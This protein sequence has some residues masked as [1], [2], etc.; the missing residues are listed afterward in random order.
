MKLYHHIKR[1]YKKNL[2]FII[3]VLLLLLCFYVRYPC[4]QK[5]KYDLSEEELISVLREMN[6]QELEKEQYQPYEKQ[7]EQILKQFMQDIKF[8][9]IPLSK[10]N[11]ERFVH[12]ENSWGMGRTFGGN[13][14]HEGTDLMAD[15]QVSG[16][17]PVISVS[18]GVVEKKGWLT[19]GGNRL[20][21]RCKN[22]GKFYY[23]HLAD[24]AEGIEE[25]KSV[26]AGQLLGFM[27]DTGYGPEGTKGKF[28]VHLHFG[29]YVRYHGQELSVNPYYVLNQLRFIGAQY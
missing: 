27:G 6:L 25:G 18:D 14:T 12:Y 28:Q 8:F 21:I 15:Y 29:I 22:G 17:Y 3:V 20:L 9:P 1:I 26:S 11:P 7:K 2:L 4:N 5:Q 13:R 10:T 19:L 16:Y 24:Y 23:A